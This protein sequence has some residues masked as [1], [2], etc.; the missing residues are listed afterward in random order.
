[1]KYGE[2]HD[3][4][5]LWD[6]S[7][8]K[9][10]TKYYKIS[11]CTTCMGR[12]HDLK[13]TL[14]LNIEAL[15]SYPNLEFVILNYNSKDKLEEWIKKNMMKHIESG[16]VVYYKTEEPEYFDMSHAKNIVSKLATGDIINNLDADNYAFD[17]R[18]KNVHK[19]PKISWAHYLNK[20]A[21]EFKEKVIFIKS[22]R[23]PHGRLG[24]YKNEFVELL[25]GYDENLKGYGYE[26][27]DLV[28]RALALGFTFCP[29]RYYYSRIRT[30]SEMINKNLKE[31]HKT[32]KQIN[33]EKAAANIEKKIFKT[34]THR[35][36][37]KAKLIKNFKEEM[38]I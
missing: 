10:V 30:G 1:M 8:R 3:I 27:F 5:I 20:I 6:G 24:F 13:E 36:W 9:E 11:F 2:R 22:N 25:G 15:K 23:V 37:G 32:T 38:E 26:D 31:Y 21:N 34:N 29:W 18:G 35:H 14:P 7:F 33:L 16:R 19:I 17:N 12:L 28:E 4:P